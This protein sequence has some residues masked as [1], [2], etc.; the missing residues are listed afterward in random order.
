[1]TTPR[2]VRSAIGSF[3]DV[4]MDELVLWPGT[5]KLDEVKRLTDV[6]AG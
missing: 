4:G 5:A 1:L 6:V 2:D 3:S